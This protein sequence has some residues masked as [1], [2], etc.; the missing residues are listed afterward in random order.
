MRSGR[1]ARIMGDLDTWQAIHAERRALAADLED[2]REDQWSTQSLCTGWTVRDV[3]AHMTAAA[4]MTPPTFFTKMLASGFSFDKV[5][6]KG[7]AA[8]KG[9]SP[10]DTLAHFEAVQ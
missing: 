9:G 2:L 6:A 3:V 8:E 1:W 4:K 10:S 7:V 5:Q